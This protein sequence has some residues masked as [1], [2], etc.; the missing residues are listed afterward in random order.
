[1]G[2]SKHLEDFF[3][4]RHTILNT[5]NKTKDLPIIKEVIN[6]WDNNID[7]IILL[8]TGGSN[9][10]SKTICRINNPNIYSQNKTKNIIF[11]DNIDPDIFY[12][13]VKE[14]NWNKTAILII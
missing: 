10:G 9:L 11:I 12:P 6:N 7:N 2:C 13:L 4:S 1:M 8:G 3:K 14:T 5:I